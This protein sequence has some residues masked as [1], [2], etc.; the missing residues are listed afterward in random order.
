ML[1]FGRAEVLFPS[2]DIESHLLR[3]VLEVLHTELILVLINHVVHLPELALPPC[4]QGSLCRVDSIGVNVGEREFLVNELHFLGIQLKHLVHETLVRLAPR[5][6]EVGE[7]DDGNGS[8]PG[9]LH[10]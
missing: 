1:H 4:R 5:T 2:E 3:I 10:W 9:T 6:L 8:V 7:L